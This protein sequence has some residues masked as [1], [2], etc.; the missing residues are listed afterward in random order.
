MQAKFASLRLYIMAPACES[1]PE[2]KKTKEDIC[3]VKFVMVKA[4]RGKLF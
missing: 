4:E 1:R 3:S 2:F